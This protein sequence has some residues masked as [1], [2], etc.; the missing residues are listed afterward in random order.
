M[1]MARQYS[2][3]SGIRMEIRIGFPRRVAAASAA[4]L[5]RLIKAWHQHMLAG[6]DL[7]PGIEPG[8]VTVF[9]PDHDETPV[10]PSS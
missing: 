10:A 7:L 4:F 1:P 9:T 6:V 5:T 2:I 8:D 3:V